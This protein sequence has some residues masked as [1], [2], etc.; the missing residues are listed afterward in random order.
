MNRVVNS[1]GRVLVT[2][3]GGFAGSALV[4]ELARRGADVVALLRP[5]T[6]RER[7]GDLACSIQFAIADL[8]DPAATRRALSSFHPNIIIHAAMSGG[9]AADSAGRLT[10]LHDSVLAT[11]NLLEASADTRVLFLGSWLVYQPSSSPLTEDDP[12]DP[13]TTRGAAKAAASLWFRQFVRARRIESAE[14]RL[15]SVYGPGESPGRFVPATLRAAITGQPLPLKPGPRHD[16]I[17][18][19]D[20]VDACLAAARA[21]LDPGEVI[22]IGS[23]VATA[24]EELVDVARRVTNR[25]IDARPGDHPGTPADSAHCAAD[26][27]KARRLLN[28]TPA[29]SLESGLLATYDWMLSRQEAA[30]AR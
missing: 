13:V 8:R 18:I 26:I 14:L 10:A 20:V 22:N 17:Y 30:C 3:A 6:N 5:E 2:G 1:L 24:N 11:A 27:S 23:G 21:P 16:F 12:L 19:A 7:L 29:H 9:H 25:P 4:R 28:W 15:F